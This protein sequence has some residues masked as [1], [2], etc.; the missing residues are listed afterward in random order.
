MFCIGALFNSSD[1]PMTCECS[2]HIGLSANYFCPRCKAGGDKKFKTSDDGYH[3]LFKV[4]YSD[5][6][7]NRVLI[8]NLHSE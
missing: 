5:N 7:I 6:V 8:N 2:S 3:S 1:N 4:M